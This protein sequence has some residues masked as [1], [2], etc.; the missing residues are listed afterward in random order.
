LVFLIYIR[1]SFSY[2]ITFFIEIALNYV[3]WS[4]IYIL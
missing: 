3:T 4:K 2:F 1:A